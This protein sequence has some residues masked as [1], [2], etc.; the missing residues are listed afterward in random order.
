[1]H[2]P[3]MGTP[4]PFRI[5]HLSDMHLTARPDQRRTGCDVFKPL[6]G[7]NAALGTILQSPLVCTCDLILVTGDITDNGAPEAWTHFWETAREAGVADK[8]RALPG[9]HD[10][11]W[12]GPARFPRRGLK[13][14][15][16]LKA[17]R[18]LQL[19]GQA[20][21][22]PWVY[23]PDPRIAIFGL[24][25]NNLGNLSVGTNAMGDLGYYQLKRLAALLYRHR[26]VPIK[27]VALH[28]SPNIPEVETAKRR[29]QRPMS[30]LERLAHQ[31]PREQRRALLLLCIAHNVRLVA[32]GHLHVEEDRRITGTR[33]VGAPAST[34]PSNAGHYHFWRYTIRRSEPRLYI[35]RHSVAVAPSPTVLKAR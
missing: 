14:A 32:H 24:N 8:I 30:R 28:H 22:F 7:M 3:A 5:A 15:D 6:T 11:C 26:E 33:I 18:G 31:I 23:L 16:L 27:I 2:G 10:V 29:R 13:Q 35:T 1:M 9:N 20:T 25:S 4:A 12:L 34:E 17:V 19:G 21:K